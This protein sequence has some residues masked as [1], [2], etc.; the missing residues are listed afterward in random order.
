MSLNIFPISGEETGGR[1]YCC[2]LFR[3]T[4]PKEE[5]IVFGKF[6]IKPSIIS[7]PF[8]LN[9]RNCRTLRR[10][11]NF[12]TIPIVANCGV[13]NQFDI[14]S[15]Y[16]LFLLAA[17]LSVNLIYINITN[18]EDKIINARGISKNEEI[19]L[20]LI[21]FC[22][23]IYGTVTFKHRVTEIVSFF[24]CSNFTFSIEFEIFVMFVL[25]WMGIYPI[26]LFWILLADPL[27]SLMSLMLL[28]PL[29]VKLSF[30]IS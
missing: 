28:N 6:I 25:C 1:N 29:P 3:K 24:I 17:D 30:L 7:A 26:L 22:F 23:F 9:F 10:S 11:Y 12:G 2:F 13:Q 27:F 19:L 8:W 14:T 20:C 15:M 16:K 5:K 21:S 4:W 18:W